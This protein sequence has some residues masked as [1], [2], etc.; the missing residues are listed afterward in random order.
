MASLLDYSISVL[1]SIFIAKLMHQEF[2]HSRVHVAIAWSS[3][4]GVIL[5]SAVEHVL[6]IA[7]AVL[8]SLKFA[9]VDGR[10]FKVADAI[11][12]LLLHVVALGTGIG[13]ITVGWQTGIGLYNR[14]VPIGHL[15]HATGHVLMSP[16]RAVLQELLITQRRI[17]IGR[18]QQAIAAAIAKSGVFGARDQ[19][20]IIFANASSS[21]RRH[22]QVTLIIHVVV[23]HLH[24][25]IHAI[26]QLGQQDIG[27]DAVLGVKGVHLGSAH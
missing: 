23:T 8:C 13:W 17:G 9:T 5:I 15:A 1:Q 24:V 16:E 11:A 14:I 19:V 7:S 6:T 21:S 25:I 26:Q 12:A 20:H 3:T 27:K 10:I 4:C 18:L 2:L 22:S